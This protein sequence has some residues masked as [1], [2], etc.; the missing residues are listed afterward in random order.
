MAVAA[1]AAALARTTSAGPSPSPG[2]QASAW[3]S[4]GT[5]GKNRRDS[6]PRGP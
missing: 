5:A 1:S 6:W 3:V 2:T 4:S